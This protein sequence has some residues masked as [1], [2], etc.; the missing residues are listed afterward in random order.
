MRSLRAIH[1]FVPVVLAAV[2]ACGEPQDAP[3]G[4]SF[5]RAP[6]GPTV[7]AASPDTAVQDTTLDV[8]VSGTGFDSGSSAEWLLAGV[9]DPRVRTN[10]TRYVSTK[11]LVAQHHHRE[12]CGA[13]EVRHC[14]DHLER[15]EGHRDR[16]VR[17]A[18]Q[19]IRVPSSRWTMLLE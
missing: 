3:L 12:R 4:P 15:Q 7:T 17:G 11:S 19:A 5:A 13:G 2:M 16:A 14:G 6:S 10:S 9:P 18:A 1:R 8:T